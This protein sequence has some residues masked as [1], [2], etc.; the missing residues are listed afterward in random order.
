VLIIIRIFSLMIVS[1][2]DVDIEDGET[3]F[4]HLAKGACNDC[5]GLHGRGQDLNRDRHVHSSHVL[6][7]FNMCVVH[8]YA[9]V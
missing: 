8:T 5:R 2:Y 4:C 7:V 9:C 6:C 1:A 3:N